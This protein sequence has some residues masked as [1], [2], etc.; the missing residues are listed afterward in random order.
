M[1]CWYGTEPNTEGKT[2]EGYDQK[3]GLARARPQVLKGGLS[4]FY[5]LLGANSGVKRMLNFFHLGDQVGGR[6]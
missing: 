2:L 6:N 3:K 1:V 5:A 4:K